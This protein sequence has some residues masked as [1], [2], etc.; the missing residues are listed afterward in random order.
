MID[1]CVAWENIFNKRQIATDI[2]QEQANQGKV[3]R[4]GISRIYNSL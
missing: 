3:L 4:G 1:N 2:E